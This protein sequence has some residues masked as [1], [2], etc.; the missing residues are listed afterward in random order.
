MNQANQGR[1]A[2]VRRTMKSDKFPI[3][4]KESRVFME[5]LLIPKTAERT[6]SQLV[7]TTVTGLT[8]GSVYTLLNNLELKGLLESRLETITSVDK[9]VMWSNRHYRLSEFGKSFY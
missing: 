2:L 3:S 6:G 7:S 8:K 5:F 9:T 4:K 1:L